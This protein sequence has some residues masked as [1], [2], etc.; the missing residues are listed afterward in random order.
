MPRP[1]LLLSTCGTSLLTNTLR[2]HPIGDFHGGHLNALSN[3]AALEDIESAP[4]YSTRRVAQ[5]SKST[6]GRS[7]D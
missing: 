7:V 2:S 3:R 6:H 4:P 5:R 1:L